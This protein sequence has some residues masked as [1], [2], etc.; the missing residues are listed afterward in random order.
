MMENNDEFYF[1]TEELEDII[2]Y[3]LELGDFNYADMAVN[4]GLKLH[5]NSLEIKIKK[6]EVLLE[7][8]DYNMA[9]ELID[10]LKG[11]F[12]GEYRLFGLLAPRYY[13]EFRKPK[14]FHRNL[15]KTRT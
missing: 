14:R 9:K 4:F 1:D 6:L 3:Y 2:V 5:P 13:S 15:Q 8:E 11:S 10:E 12:Y 7:W